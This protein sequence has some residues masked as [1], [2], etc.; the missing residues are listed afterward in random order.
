MAANLTVLGFGLLA[1]FFFHG[2]ACGRPNAAILTLTFCFTP[3]FLLNCATCMDYVPAL[4]LLLGSAWLALS[5]RLTSA[6]LMLGLSAGFRLTGILGGLPLWLWLAGQR[7]Y[8]E[9][10]TSTAL[11]TS[12]GLA[13]YLPGID[14]YGLGMFKVPATAVNAAD[15]LSQ[16]GYRAWMCLGLPAWLGLGWLL[17]KSRGRDGM[18]RSVSRESTGRL[19]RMYESILPPVYF[20]LFLLHPDEISYLL[21]AVTFLILWIG[22]HIPRRETFVLGLLLFSHGLLCLNPLGG[23]S[24]KRSLRLHLAP[25]LIVNDWLERRELNHLRLGLD[26][27]S[28]PQHSVLITG[29]GDILTFHNPL[30]EPPEAGFSTLIDPAG[31]WEP[32]QTRLLRGRDIHLVHTLSSGNVQRLQAAGYHLFMFSSFAPST[33]LRRYGFDPWQA[34]IGR[35]EAFGPEAFYR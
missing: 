25:G 22:K 30:L 24:G 8:R 1:L 31:I 13:F 34:G 4:A 20:L 27:L 16:A 18:V 29:M 23:E 17:V 12:V 3:V 26:K 15:L 9:A 6:A 2:L 33:T 14:R 7:R 11:A 28:L 10:L 19:E 5:G 21:P 32:G 35:V